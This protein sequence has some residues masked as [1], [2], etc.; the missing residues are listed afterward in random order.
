MKLLAALVPYIAVLLG[1]TL[2]RSAWITILLYHA[3][4]LLFLFLRL[5]SNLW[6]TVW[7]GMRT[8]LLIPSVII[9]AMAAP[10]VYFMWPIFQSPYTRLTVWLSFYGLT[11]LAWLLMI[12]YFSIIHP[13]LEEIHWRGIA[14][15]HF[16]PLCWQDFMFAGYHVLVLHE[17]I[18]RPWLLLIF[19]VLVASSVFW[20]WTADKFGGYGL[21]VLTHAAADAGVMIGVRFLL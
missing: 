17:L 1:M 20:R 3:G 11:G 21:P 6:K 5:P 16:V 18:F 4:I 15:D 8:P 12:P 2:L 10:V 13:V 7:G 19:G 14:P 9:C